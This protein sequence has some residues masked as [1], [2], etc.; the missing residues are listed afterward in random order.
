VWNVVPHLPVGV[1]RR[2]EE[3][4]RNAA[5]YA[6]PERRSGHERRIRTPGLL[7]PGLEGGWLC[8]ENH[9]DKRRLTPIPECWEDCTD[10]QLEEFCR[11]AASVRRRGG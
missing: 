3:R 4:R 5:P 2:S 10:E 7:T 9:S 6:G 1:E 11:Q 8:F